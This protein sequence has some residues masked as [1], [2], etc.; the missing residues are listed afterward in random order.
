[1]FSSPSFCDDV[2]A[3]CLWASSRTSHDIITHCYA[4]LNILRGKNI[5]SLKTLRIAKYG[6]SA[7]RAVFFPPWWLSF[8]T[9]PYWASGLCKSLLLGTRPEE[10]DV[11]PKATAVMSGVFIVFVFI[12]STSESWIIVKQ[13]DFSWKLHLVLL[14]SYMQRPPYEY[15]ATSVPERQVCKGCCSTG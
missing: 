12:I 2:V 14:Y 6:F 5:S 4:T 7:R 11:R 9:K 13:R 10:Q 15:P 8:G 3:L 1:M